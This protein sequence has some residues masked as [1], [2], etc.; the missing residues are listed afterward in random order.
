MKN[1]KTGDNMKIMILVPSFGNSSPIYGAFLFAKYLN[2]HDVNVMLVSLDTNYNSK[3]SII[4]DITK[5]NI[6]YTCLN[7]KGWCGLIFKHQ[8]LKN[9][10]KENNI[11][12]IIS[13]LLRPDLACAS[14]SDVVRISSVRGMLRRQ[15]LLLHGKFLTNIVMYLQ[16]KSLKKMDLVL[17]MSESMSK[18]LISEGIDSA[19]LSI[20]NNFVDVNSIRS[21]VNNN[22]SDNTTINIGIFCKLLPRKR[23]DVAIRA[24]SKLVYTHKYRNVKLHIAGD[25][26]QLNDLKILVEK[27]AITGHVIFHGFITHPFQLMNDM[28]L[29][30]LTS[31]AEGFPRCLMEALSLGKTI[32]TSD[33]PGVHEMIEDKING[34]L[35]PVGSTDKLASLIA[36][37]IQNKSYLPQEQLVSFAMKN[38]DV[39]ICCKEMLN[40][41]RRFYSALRFNKYEQS[42][43]NSQL[44]NA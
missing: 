8:I 14:L 31:E 37:I 4:A 10:V 18:W 33:I 26:Q 25:G 36:N 21:S 41:I 17:S 7:I 9:F 39:N 16:M 11:N 23:V 13:Y 30:V 40:T 22:A 29:I 12:A 2:E 27:M 35:F 28:D 32:I 1:K 38:C 3:K 43:S 5:A 42:L 19:R 6:Y 20:I 24:I 34:Y 15:H 44:R